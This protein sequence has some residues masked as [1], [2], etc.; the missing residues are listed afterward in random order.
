MP[1]IIFEIL[2]DRLEKCI[3][4]LCER[5]CNSNSSGAGTVQLESTLNT[6]FVIFFKVLECYHR[7]NII[8]GE[9]WSKHESHRCVECDFIFR[10]SEGEIHNIIRL[11]DGKP[12]ATADN[13]MPT[14]GVFARKEYT[15]GF[16]KYRN[17]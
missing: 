6:F 9:E 13:I 12:H 1:R 11:D 7:F 16:C 17:T 8:N 4:L 2:I 14:I 3:K 15:A 10:M 5:K